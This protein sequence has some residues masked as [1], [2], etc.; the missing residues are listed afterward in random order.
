MLALLMRT[1]AP[2]GVDE[3][4]RAL[5]RGTGDLATLYRVFESFE[6][7]GLARRV[8]LRHAHADFEYAGLP[9]H[10]HLVCLSCGRHEDFTGCESERLSRKALRAS[11]TFKRVV[12]HAI[13]LYG[14][15]RDCDRGRQGL[16]RRRA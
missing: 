7:V 14:Y 5:P 16:Q 9:D 12:Q 10:H 3:A 11:K 2:I 13:E 1:A 6:R 4:R 15:C 8:D